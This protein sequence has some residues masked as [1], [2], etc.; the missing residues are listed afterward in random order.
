MSLLYFEQEF[1]Y[2][3]DSVKLKEDPRMKAFLR[4][5]D[6]IMC[7]IQTEQFSEGEDPGETLHR[8]T[9]DIVMN[10][11]A[12]D[13]SGGPISGRIDY[14]SAFDIACAQNPDLAAR[15]IQKME[16]GKAA[17][18]SKEQDTTNFSNIRRK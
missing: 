8:K 10:P 13:M 18:S 3:G 14:K 12:A 1:E 17:K 5:G 6:E 7:N 4:L 11:P 16:E 15:Y 2:G 9:M